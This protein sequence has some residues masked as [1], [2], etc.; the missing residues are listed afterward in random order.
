MARNLP[1]SRIPDAAYPAQVLVSWFL[2]KSPLVGADITLGANAP[3]SNDTLNMMDHQLLC[4]IERLYDLT[5]LRGDTASRP[6]ENQHQYFDTDLGLPI[7]W[8]E[9]DWVDATGTNV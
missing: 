2:N 1:F 7:W 8:N 9:T 5:A 3:L 4:N 6:T